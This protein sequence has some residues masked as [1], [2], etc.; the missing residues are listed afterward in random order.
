MTT[1]AGSFILTETPYKTEGTDGF[2]YFLA[3]TLGS[4][5]EGYRSFETCYGFTEILPG[6]ITANMIRS[7]DAYT[8]FN[9]AEG[10]IGGNIRIKTGS[11]YMN[12]SDR[13]DL[14]VYATYVDFEVLSDRISASVTSINNLTNRINSAGWITKAEANILYTYQEDL[15]N[16]QKLIS[17]INQTAGSTTIYSSRIN[18][19][20]AVYFDSLSTDMKNRLNGKEEHAIDT[21][22][23]LFGGS[24]LLSHVSKRAC[25]ELRVIYNDL[26]NY[27]LRVQNVRATNA[28]LASIRAVLKDYPDDRKIAPGSCVAKCCG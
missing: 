12:L 14:S 8:Y 18:L 17:Y 26:D 15:I 7:A 21:V 13:P 16:G 22:V 4:E 20:G 9:L 1:T 2:Y 25:P 19:S 24:G 23:D 6:R 10:E 28:L 3:G 11:G 27:H 5:W